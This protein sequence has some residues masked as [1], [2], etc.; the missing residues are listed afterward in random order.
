MR[1]TLFFSLVFGV[2]VAM[3]LF[4]KPA[5]IELPDHKE[6]AELEFNDFTVYKIGKKGV[7]SILRGASSKKFSDR[8]E[9][10]KIVVEDA[11]QDG[12]LY[13]IFADAGIYKNDHIYL[14]SQVKLLQENGFVFTS[15]EA[16]YDING[17]LVTTKGA[18]RIASKYDTIRGRALAFY[19]DENRL[20]AK[21]IVAIYET[22]RE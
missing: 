13:K 19:L 16:Q 10:E 17:S 5:R 21:D 9:I 14:S 1:V 15:N 22:E 2:L 8:Y 18:F 11:S 3:F 20:H 12:E 7:E 6:V 4:L